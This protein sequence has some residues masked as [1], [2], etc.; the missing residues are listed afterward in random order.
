MLTE[1]TD[2]TDSI[3]IRSDGSLEI[4]EAMRI[5]RDGAEISKEYHR[6]LLHPG[7][8]TTGKDPRIVKTAKAVWTAD[9]VAAFK[10]AQSI[11]ET[12]E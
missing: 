11:R 12:A 10:A 2:R 3:N 1:K 8:D 4:R 5:F 6:Y 9:V 7:D